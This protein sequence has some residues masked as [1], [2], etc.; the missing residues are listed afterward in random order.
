[1]IVVPLTVVSAIY[2]AAYATAFLAGASVSAPTWPAGRVAV[3]LAVNLPILSL[4]GLA[5][6]LGEEIGWRGYLQPR[7]DQLNVHFSMLWVI[8]LETL[9]HVPLIVLADYLGGQ[10]RVINRRVDVDVVFAFSRTNN[11]TR[12]NLLVSRALRGARTS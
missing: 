4:V 3:N 11:P 12:V 1:V 8:A 2:L 7:L 10:N 9:F 6:A 5:G